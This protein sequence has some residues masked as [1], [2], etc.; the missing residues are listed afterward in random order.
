MKRVKRLFACLLALTMMLGLSATAF[1]AGAVK[2]SDVSSVKIN[3]CYYLKGEGESPAETFT[4][5]V[6]KVSVA[7]SENTVKN[8]PE[9]KGFDIAY[10]K[11]DA[12]TAGTQKNHMLELPGV[13]DFKRPGVYTYNITEKKGNTAGVKYDEGKVQL[14][15]TVSYDENGNLIRTVALRKGDSK[16]GDSNN[17]FENTYIANKLSIKKIVAGNLG[18]KSRAF[19]FKVE[20]KKTSEDYTKTSCTVQGGSGEYANVRKFDSLPESI[21]ISLKHGETITIENLPKGVEYTVTETS[22][23]DYTTT[24]G[25][26]TTKTTTGTMDEKA[27][28]VE[29]T[30]KKQNDNIDTGVYLDNLPYILVFAGVLAIAAVFVVRRRRFE[31]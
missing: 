4:F 27:K 24:V 5:E 11:G 8:M 21:Y 7:N 1:A 10:A 15:V 31:D 25:S 18:D 19:D 14:I 9:I 12:T 6:T 30:N 28:T 22:G 17:A 29:F 23:D 16:L 3:K 26:D 20:L 13:K 2:L